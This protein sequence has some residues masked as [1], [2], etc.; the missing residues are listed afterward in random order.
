[1]Y[2]GGE[3]GEKN[4]APIGSNVVNLFLQ[5]VGVVISDIQDVIFKYVNVLKCLPPPQKLCIT[6]LYHNKCM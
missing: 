4:A 5:S 2:A 6:C 1:M 3:G